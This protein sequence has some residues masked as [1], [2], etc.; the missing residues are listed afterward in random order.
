MSGPVVGGTFGP[1]PIDITL[2]SDTL[3]SVGSGRLKWLQQYGLPFGTPSLL[4]LVIA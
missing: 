1:Q 2:T 4:R 3:T